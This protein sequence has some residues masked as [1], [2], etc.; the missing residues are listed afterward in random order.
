MA[1]MRCR[2]SFLQQAA[3]EEV[4]RQRL[5]RML[6]SPEPIWKLEDHPELKDGAMEWVERMRAED[7]GL[8]RQRNRR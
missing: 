4:K 7:E 8:D 3:W 2:S 6:E 1:N 5:L